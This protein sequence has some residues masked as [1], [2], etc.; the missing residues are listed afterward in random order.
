MVCKHCWG[1]SG[2]VLVNVIHCWDHLGKI[3][4]CT[5]KKGSGIFEK[6]DK[7]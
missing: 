5:R 4:S 1:G 6:L 2:E 7:H 3:G